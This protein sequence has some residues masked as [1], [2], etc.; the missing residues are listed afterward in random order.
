MPSR[1]REF[2]RRGV[3]RGGRPEDAPEPAVRAAFEGFDGAAGAPLLPDPVAGR[4][5]GDG[6]LHASFPP[7]FGS[8]SARLL[9]L[10]KCMGLA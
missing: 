10:A 2:W 7:F 3:E 4:P 6:P 5:G 9:H 1:L 8:L